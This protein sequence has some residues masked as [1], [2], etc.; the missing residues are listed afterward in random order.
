M[1]NKRFKYDFFISYKHGKLDSEIASYL[2][3]QLEHYK[4]PKDIRQKSKKDRIS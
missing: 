1:D 2:Q 3:Q 4:V